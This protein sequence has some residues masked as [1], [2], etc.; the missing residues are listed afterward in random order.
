[1]L[2]SPIVSVLGHV[3]HGKTKILDYIRGTGMVAKEAGKITQHVGASVL[4]KD[5]ILEK[6]G[7]LLQKYGFKIDIPGIL[8]EHPQ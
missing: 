6:C 5:V 1:M 8:N 4:P 7:N 2:R 3:D